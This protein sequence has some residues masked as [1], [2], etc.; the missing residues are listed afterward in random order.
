MADA[1]NPRPPTGAAWRA[2]LAAIGWYALATLAAVP[3]LLLEK[4]GH[5]PAGL[6]YGLMVLVVP[7]VLLVPV[8]RAG[9][10]RDWLR[11]PSAGVVETALVFAAVLAANIVI[12]RLFAVGMPDLGK[13]GGHGVAFAWLPFLAIAIAAPVAEELFF[14][15]WLWERLSRHWPRRWVATATA[16]GFAA[17]HLQYVA[18]VV[19]AT[20]ALTWLR[21]RGGLRPPLA[22]HL[23]INTLAAA[24]ALA[25]G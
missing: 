20:I 10:A 21:L 24:I 4:G 17:A 3:P 14:R 22:L 12:V 5:L 13:G 1:T 8:L 6:G 25:G 18:S 11:A 15:G 2:L 16:I 19:P 9:G 23:A 7:L